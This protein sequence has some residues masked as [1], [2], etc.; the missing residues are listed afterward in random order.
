MDV[1][2]NMHVVI[3]VFYIIVGDS[4]VPK[5]RKCL[6]NDNN[7]DKDKNIFR[8]YPEE[9]RRRNESASEECVKL[10]EEIQSGLSNNKIGL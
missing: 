1:L 5:T 2:V 6:M 8:V 7:K 10:A 4:T 9:T 3:F